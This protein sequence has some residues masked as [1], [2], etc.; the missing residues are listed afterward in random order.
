MAEKRY[1]SVSRGRKL[2]PQEAAEYQEVRR[3]VMEEIPPATTSVVREAVEQL[4]AELG[5]RL[6]A[7]ELLPIGSPRRDW[8]M[9]SVADG[10]VILRDPDL[11]TTLRLADRV[12]QR[13]QLFAG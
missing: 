10:Y 11:Q 12:G 6:V 9:T 5:D 7:V 4:R 13:L 3:K 8:K 2:T 1:R